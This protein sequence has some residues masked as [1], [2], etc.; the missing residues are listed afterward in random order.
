MALSDVV[1]FQSVLDG[2]VFNSLLTIS[3]RCKRKPHTSVFL[4]QCD[5]LQVKHEQF[6]AV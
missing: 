2:G 6:T 4:F 1:E 5:D 3:A